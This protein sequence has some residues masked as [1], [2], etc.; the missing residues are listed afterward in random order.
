MCGSGYASCKFV[1]ELKQQH[2]GLGVVQNRQYD[3]QKGS[4]TV[5]YQH[6]KFHQTKESR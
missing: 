5:G 1:G 4:E 3:S 2:V 6:L